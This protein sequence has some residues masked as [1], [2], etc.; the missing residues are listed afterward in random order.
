MNAF[1]VPGSQFVVGDLVHH[2][3]TA[4]LRTMFLIADGAAPSSDLLSTPCSIM[5]Q[6][7]FRSLRNT[8][9]YAISHQGP[10]EV[11]SEM[12]KRIT[13]GAHVIDQRL[14]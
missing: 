2:R 6:R 14:H 7:Q 13:L 8:H 3:Y 4:I 12:L 5:R 9:V 10:V 1:C 11:I